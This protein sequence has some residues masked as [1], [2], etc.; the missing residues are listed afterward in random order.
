MAE[1]LYV[2]I[3][4]DVALLIRRAFLPLNP[5]K[6]RKADPKVVTAAHQ[7]IAAI[8]VARPLPLFPEGVFKAADGN[9][10]RLVRVADPTEAPK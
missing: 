6:M 3:P 9:S 10:Y 8:G 2:T 4:A 7:F 1:L 5:N